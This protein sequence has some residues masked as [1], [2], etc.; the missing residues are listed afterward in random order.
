M[1]PA[2]GD[3]SN[4]VVK[5]VISRTLTRRSWR[6]RRHRTRTTHY[7]L[8]YS[9]S[10]M[11]SSP[12]PSSLRYHKVHKTEESYFNLK[13]WCLESWN[14][15]GS[16]HKFDRCRWTTPEKDFYSHRH[17]WKRRRSVATSF[18]LGVTFEQCYKATPKVATELKIMA[19]LICG[20]KRHIIWG[21]VWVRKGNTG[22]FLDNHPH[23]GVRVCQV[24]GNSRAFPG[25]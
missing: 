6:R 2:R 19:A 4:F 24:G 11:S 8:M 22:V 3:N 7:G 1:L 20:L 13:P 12:R 14:R 23:Y 17:V 10:A 5:T 25:F 18:L 16:C 21:Y 15:R 9:P